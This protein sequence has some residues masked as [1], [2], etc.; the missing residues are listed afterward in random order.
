MVER[1]VIGAVPSFLIESA[2]SN[3]PNDDFDYASWSGR[4]MA[5]LAH[6]YNGTMDASCVRSSD[7]MEVNRIKYLFHPTQ[8]WTH[9]Q[10]HEFASEAWNYVGFG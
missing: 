2:V 10:A 1:G 3:V 7:W 6:I 4:V 8:N 9:E 5:A